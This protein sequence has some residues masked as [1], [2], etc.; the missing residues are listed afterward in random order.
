MNA[1]VSTVDAVEGV[2]NFTLIFGGVKNQAQNLSMDIQSLATGLNPADERL[3]VERFSYQ[4]GIVSFA[5]HY[6]NQEVF[7][8]FNESLQKCLIETYN[9]ADDDFYIS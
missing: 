6:H 7:R 1:F 5:L 4:A 3:S 2:K 9:L 8:L